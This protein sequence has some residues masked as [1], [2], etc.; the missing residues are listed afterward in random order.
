MSTKWVFAYKFN[1]DG[2]VT[3][4]KSRFVVRGFSQKEGIDFKE[5]FAPTARFT[6]LMILFSIAVKKKSHIR[7]FDIVVAY[8]HSPIDEVVYIKPAEGY[9]LEDKTKVLKLI[10]ALYGTKQAER[11]WWK[12]FSTVLAGIR[13]KYCI[14]DQSFYVLHYTGDTA[15]LWIH[16]N[17]GA[18]CGSS[19]GILGFIRE[20][21]LKS[22]D[23][24]WTEKLTQIVGIKIDY[25]TR[26]IFL[27]QPTLT[28]SILEKCGFPTS[29]VATP[30]VAN[31]KL[32]SS[33]EG[34]LGVDGSKYLSVL[35]SL[36]YLAIGTR[37]DLAFAVTF[38]AR[39]SSRPN[40]EHWLAI[41]HLLRYVSGTKNEGILFQDPSD[42]TPVI[43][44]CDANWGGGGI[45][46]IYPWF[47][48]D[49]VWKPNLMGISTTRLCCYINLSC[50]IY[51]AWSSGK[52]V[53]MDS[54]SID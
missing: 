19:I 17:D 49:V 15:L 46:A 36:L 10:K 20:N 50:R 34:T 14:N 18:I 3:R 37:P 16:V 5:T 27:S 41:K 48:S 25:T 11:F 4:R 47:H 8:P 51:G 31:L 26:G 39:F 33:E 35:G 54:E 9:P 52:R 32:E 24:T 44:Y 2:E 43:T 28:S 23:V 22:F 45:L 42:D 13:C 6:S 1:S 7:G 12:H 21:L 53:Y 29:R 30:M 38:L 40:S